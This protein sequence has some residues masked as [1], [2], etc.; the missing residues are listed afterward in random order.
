MFAADAQVS[1]RFRDCEKRLGN[2]EKEAL[3]INLSFERKF[4]EI[5]TDDNNLGTLKLA[6]QALKTVLL[7]RQITS[8]REVNVRDTGDKNDPE[9]TGCAVMPNGHVVICDHNND[10][11]KL[12][13]APLR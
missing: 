7:G 6:E 5:L 4:D 9:V 2:L 1:K 8:R 3:K 10:K 12:L 13:D 11:I